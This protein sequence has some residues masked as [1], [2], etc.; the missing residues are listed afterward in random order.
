MQDHQSTFPTLPYLVLIVW[1]LG[2]PS[3]QTIAYFLIHSNFSLSA[4]LRT[5]EQA[6]PLPASYGEHP[7]I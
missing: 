3:S 7:N 5:D 1:F 2:Q 4:P 6:V